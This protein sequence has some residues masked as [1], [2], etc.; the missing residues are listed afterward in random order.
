MTEVEIFEAVYRA[1][2]SIDKL[3]PI[4]VAINGV[5]GT[6]KTTFANG[7]GRF[8]SLKG[9][10]VLN[11][12]IDG[13]HFNKEYRYKQ[14]VDSALGYYQDSYDEK[15]FVEKVLLSSQEEIPKIT[16]ATHSLVSD[17][18]LDLEPIEIMSNSIL[19]TD[20]AY[21]FKS[22]YRSYWDLKIYLSTD[23]E[24]ALL[25]GTQRDAEMLGGLDKAKDKF[26][27]RYH[28]ASRIY[29]AENKPKLIADI[30]INNSDFDNL[31]IE[32]NV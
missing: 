12:S 22:A 19:I 27:R 13:F 14:G 3:K 31:T 29:I 15:S 18:Y 7:L 26:R 5:E 24:T 21:L 20:G 8:L 11:V 6:G 1:I 9:E 17:E 28:E 2:V 16:I 30:I 10:N 4:R 32:K 25:R 23:F